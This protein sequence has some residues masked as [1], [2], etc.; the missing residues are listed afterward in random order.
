MTVQMMLQSIRACCAMVERLRRA[1]ERYATVEEKIEEIRIVN[2]AKWVLIEKR[3]MS[4]PEAHRFIEK[5][6][7]DRRLPR[8]LVAQEILGSETV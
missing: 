6:A 3:G 1:E 5:E 2:R 7:M 8:S 4:E